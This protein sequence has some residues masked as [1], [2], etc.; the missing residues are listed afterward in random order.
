MDPVNTY[1]KSEVGR[2]QRASLKGVKIEVTTMKNTLVKTNQKRHEYISRMEEI[3]Q[4]KKLGV[5]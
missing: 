4:M 2:D 3:E 5:L 1:F